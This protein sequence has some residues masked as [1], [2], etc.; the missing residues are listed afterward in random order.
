MK[1]TK[2]KNINLD[3][4]DA[5]TIISYRNIAFMSIEKAIMIKVTS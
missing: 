4:A 5:K 1:I 2:I 3:L